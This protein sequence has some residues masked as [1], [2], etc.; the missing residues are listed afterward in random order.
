MEFPATGERWGVEYR[1]GA[2]PSVRARVSGDLLVV[3]GAVE[4]AEACLAALRRWLHRAAGERLLDWLAE[5]SAR[6]GLAYTRGTVRGQ[7][8]RWGSCSSSGSISL[9]RCLVFLPPELARA[10]ILHELAHLRHANHSK[11]FW[12][13][14]AALDPHAASHRKAIAHAWDAV[15]PWAEP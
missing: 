1:S 4:D 5:E 2:S 6:T 8:H 12:R 10:V 13:E 15:P 9:N 7:R 3:Q 14:L 11:A